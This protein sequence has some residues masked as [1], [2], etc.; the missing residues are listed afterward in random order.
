[1]IALKTC[2]LY[3][4]STLLRLLPSISSLNIAHAWAGYPLCLEF[5]QGSQPPGKVR[6]FDLWSGKI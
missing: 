3:Y 1:M 6:E 4:I 2:H 5:L